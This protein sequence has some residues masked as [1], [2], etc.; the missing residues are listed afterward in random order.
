MA[1]ITATEMVGVT[2][3]TE[4]ARRLIDALAAGKLGPPES[5]ENVA[6][7]KKL[8][9]LLQVASAAERRRAAPKR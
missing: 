8:A 2:F 4:E 6:L 9:V 7:G 5:L 1:R 3:T